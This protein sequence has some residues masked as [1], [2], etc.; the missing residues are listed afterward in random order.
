MGKHSRHMY[1]PRKRSCWTCGRLKLAK[2]DYHNVLMN[3]LFCDANLIGRKS[4]EAL[5]GGRGQKCKTC[6]QRIWTKSCLERH[7]CQGKTLCDKCGKTIWARVNEKLEDKLAEHKC[8]VRRCRNCFQIFDDVEPIHYCPLQAQ[9]YPT[10]YSRISVYDA[11][12]FVVNADGVLK[13]NILNL[14]YETNVLG[15]FQEFH[16]FMICFSTLTPT[17]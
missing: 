6:D 13:C 17:G 14:H 1:C 11:E 10:S 7:K 12:T 2:E 16:L 5:D 9:F 8:G 3:R 15:Q 4:V